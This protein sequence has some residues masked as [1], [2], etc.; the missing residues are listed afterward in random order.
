MNRHWGGEIGFEVWRA[1]GKVF[2]S[3]YD[4]ICLGLLGDLG[5]LGGE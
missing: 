3:V 1:L 2:G 5:G 4:F